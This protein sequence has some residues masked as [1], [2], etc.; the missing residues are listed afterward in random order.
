MWENKNQTKPS[1]NKGI[2]LVTD[3]ISSELY[4]R[5]YRVWIAFILEGR[6][7]LAPQGDQMKA[8]EADLELHARGCQGQ[9]QDVP[10]PTLMISE[11][12]LSVSKTLHCAEG[13]YPCS[14][15]S[16]QDLS[17]RPFI[18]DLQMYCAGDCPLLAP[19]SPR[20]L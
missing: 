10:P 19:Q 15:S 20:E 11:K 7:I 17:L 14:T 4:S 6:G 3:S 9:S 8:E 2:A 5:R 1:Q 12:L 18:S 16:L 13:I